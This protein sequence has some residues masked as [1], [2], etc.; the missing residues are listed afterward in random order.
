MSKYKTAQLEYD[1][2]RMKKRKHKQTNKQK[3]QNN[4]QQTFG[5]IK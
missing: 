3:S 4:K 5:T 1:K 2:K